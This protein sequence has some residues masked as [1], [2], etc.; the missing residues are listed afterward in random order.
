MVDLLGRRSSLRT[1]LELWWRFGP[2]IRL[3]R[4][5]Q[6]IRIY[7][8]PRLTPEGFA[9]F[10][11]WKVTDVTP[12]AEGSGTDWGSEL[13]P[14][15]MFVVDLALRVAIQQA[16]N[17]KRAVGLQ[18]VR[19]AYLLKL[20][21]FGEPHPLREEFLKLMHSRLRSYEEAIEKGDPLGVEFAIGS[22]LV[23]FIDGESQEQDML[24]VGD[25]VA[26]FNSIFDTAQYAIACLKLKSA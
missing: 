13:V 6:R 23:S 10:L 8:G 14:M 7:F 16:K 20:R 15:R 11:V 12:P 3:F 2:R 22:R 19:E 24:K 17:T 9:A 5:S 1:R 4:I 18:R 21:D 25:A 26:E